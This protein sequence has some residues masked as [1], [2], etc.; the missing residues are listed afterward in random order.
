LDDWQ[1]WV[2]I[3]VALLIAYAVLLWLGL[4]VWTYF[5]MKDRSH[6]PVA[7]WVATGAVFLFN[8]PGFFLYL[9]FRPHETLVEAYERRLESE[10]LKAELAEQ[11]RTCPNCRRATRDDFLLCP[12]CKTVLQEPCV[13]CEKPLELSWLICPYCGTAGPR[14]TAP[15]APAPPAAAVPPPMEP[16]PAQPPPLTTS[17]AKPAASRSRTR[18]AGR[19]ATDSADGGKAAATEASA[20]TTTPSSPAS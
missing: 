17:A 15:A 11:H 5:D 2:A 20:S 1:F 16:A 10:A 7:R 18:S 9:I 3:G 8:I 19:P 4:V 14:A 13:H 12:N 6:D